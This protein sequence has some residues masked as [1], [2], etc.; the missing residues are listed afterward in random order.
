MRRFALIVGLLCVSAVNAENWPSWRGPK[1]T[2]ESGEKGLPI[3]WGADKNVAWKLAMPGRGGSTPAIWGDRMFL[4]SAKGNDQVLLCVDTKGKELWK[5]VV[6]S[7]GRASIKGDEANE[8]SASPSTDGKHVFV[9]VGTGNFACYD[10]DGKEIW[11]V[12]IQKRYG[13]F[14]I[15]HGLHS[16]PLLHEDRLYLSLQHALGHW[17]IA[18]DKANGNEIWKHERKT[19]AMGESLEAYASPCLWDDGKETQIVILGADYATGHRIKDGSEIW[20]LGDLNPKAKYSFAFRIITSPVAT[21]EALVVPTAR[22]TH[23]V[24]LKPG[25]TGFVKAGSEFEMWRKSKGSPDV[26]SPLVHDGLVYLCRENGVLQCW[27]LK[28]G[29][30]K[31]AGR[32]HATRY[33]ASPTYAEG[34]IYLAARDGTFSVVKAGPKF[35]LLATNQLPDAF[36]ASPAISEGTIYLRGFEN[37]YAIRKG[38]K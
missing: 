16:T 12:D 17:V 8:A 28:T 21:P 5:K 19:D 18:I 37:L 11:N 27:D 2:G 4:T 25:V 26:P 15:E 33:R 32:L 24:T 14:K 20:R 35:E 9:F 13:K 23:V 31:Y 3:E 38:A 34:R 30:E 1:G 22:G 10:F 36:T 6:G 7:G 29:E